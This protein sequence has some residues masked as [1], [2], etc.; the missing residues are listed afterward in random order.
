MAK[1][2]VMYAGLSCNH[3]HDRP[4]DCRPCLPKRLRKARLNYL[5]TDGIITKIPPATAAEREEQDE[6]LSDY[7]WE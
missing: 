5:L 2:E 4:G 6:E 7:N 3:R 1:Y